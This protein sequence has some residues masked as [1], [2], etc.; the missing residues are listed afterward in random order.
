MLFRLMMDK[1]KKIHNMRCPYCS[2]EET[3]VKDSRPSEDGSTIR[4]RRFCS[5]CGARFTTAERVHIR[6]LNVV[7]RNG[8]KVPY[9][10]EKLYRSLEIALR[11][12]P[13][14]SEKIE[15]IVNQVTRH[16]ESSGESDIHSKDIGHYVTEKL[17]A[18]DKVAYIRYVS[19]YWDFKNPQDFQD[20]LG[21]IKAIAECEA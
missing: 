2:H 13:I 17:L 21:R 7:K 5:Q 12:R 1:P 11:K 15:T 6:Q 9:N 14:E 19:V 3:Q 4:R 10:R 8:R 20:V 18:L 16:F